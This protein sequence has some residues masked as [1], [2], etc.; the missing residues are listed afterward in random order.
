MRRQGRVFRRCL[1]CR[2]RFTG[3]RCARCGSDRFSWSYQ[4]DVSGPKEPRKQI[5][6]SG[7][8]GESAARSAMHEA[9]SRAESGTPEPTTMTVGQWLDQWLPTARSRMRRG[10]WAGVDLIARRHL[11]P[12]IGDVPMRRLTRAQVSALYASLA[13]DGSSIRGGGLSPKSIRNVHMVLRSAL[14]DAVRDDLIPRNP[15]QDAAVPSLA[16]RVEM[17]TWTPQQVATFL[18]TAEPDRLYAMWRLAA[19]T[20][21]RRGELIGLRW[22]N[23][24]LDG[25]FVSV[26]EQL[27]RQGDRGVVFGEPKTAKGRR[28]V[29]IDAVTVAALRAHRAAQVV[30]G[31]EDLAFDRGDGTPLDPDGVTDAFLALSRRADLPRIRLHDLR[32]TAA[33]MMLRAGVHAKVVQERLGHATIGMTLDLYSHAVPAMAAEAADTI[34]ALVDEA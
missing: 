30:V 17:R 4:V 34:A 2:A 28:R 24:D 25:A 16:G 26:Q 7:F 13:E 5:M 10:S 33:T 14:Q 32:H 20:G 6:R 15:A 19:M 31:I 9:Q 12:R 1:D 3:R 18:R 23:V 22:R 11:R 8:A 21:M 29:P 27:V